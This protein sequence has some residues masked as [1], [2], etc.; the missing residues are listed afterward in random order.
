M[1][2]DTRSEVIWDEAT[3]G[4]FEFS[5]TSTD[6]DILKVAETRHTNNSM[7]V[8]LAFHTETNSAF[9]M[10]SAFKAFLNSTQMFHV[11]GEEQ[12]ECLGIPFYNFPVIRLGWGTCLA[13]R[14]S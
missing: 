13:L 3:A 5:T 12:S 14:F 8:F 2:K 10:S 7:M 11:S 9:S 4:V 6:R 1:R